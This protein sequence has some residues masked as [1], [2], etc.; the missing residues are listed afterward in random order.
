VAHMSRAPEPALHGSIDADGI[1][2]HDF[3]RLVHLI[4]RNSGICLQSSK[5]TMLEGRL[6]RRSRALGFQD[7]GEYCNFVLDS[8]ESKAEIEHLIN[9]V[10]TNKTDFFREKHHFDYL[11]NTILRAYREERRT[12]IRCW[13]AGC[14][15]GAEPYTLAMLLEDDRSRNL[16]ADYAILATDLD[17]NVLEIARRGIFASEMATPIPAGLRTRFV[18]EASDPR[19]AEVR[20]VPELRS[21]IGFAQL[22]LM[23]RHYPVGSAMDMIFC[24]NVLIY[25]DRETQEQ[26]IRRLVDCLAPGG[27]LF[28]GH[29]ETISGFDCALKTVAGTVLQRI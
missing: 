6:R 3:A 14:S 28:L 27:Y 7:L 24:R 22:N 21:K 13:S 1:P 10:T 20:I 23:D 2:G 19:R 26:V 5:K 4:R 9:A 15:T 18:L 16:G 8:G 12:L 17:T 11:K 29:S 25:F